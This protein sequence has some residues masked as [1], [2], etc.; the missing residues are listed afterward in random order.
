MYFKIRQKFLLSVINTCAKAISQAAPHPALSG[1]KINCYENYLEFIGS[2]SNISI[3]T[4]IYPDGDNGLEIIQTG[5]VVID[6]KYLLEIIRKIKNDLIEIEVIDGGYTKISSS[7]TE[8]KINGLRVSEYPAIDF[9][10]NGDFFK[11]KTSHL[12]N[13]IEDTAFAISESEI[14]PALTGINLLGKDNTI[15]AI[16]TDSYRL[17][18]KIINTE[19]T[20]DFTLIIPA[21][22]LK[23]IH[24]VI[25]D[26]E[27]FELAVSTKKIQI[28]TENTLL[29]TRL[30]DEVYPDTSK[31]IAQE[32]KYRFLVETR[33]LAEAIDR[34]L[35]IR[36]EG[37][38]IV[39]MHIVDN[40]I[41]LT[42]S[43]Q[44]VG[45]YKEDIEIK[46]FQGEEITI[47]CSGKF[48]LEAL[49]SFKGDEVEILL[50][51]EL[52]PIILRRKNDDSLIQLVS[53]VRTYN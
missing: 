37:K 40:T 53:P 9:S 2:D 46:E 47:S 51:G 42:S 3:K 18:K 38:N 28:K 22:S 5:G 13:I 11:F 48:L 12:I 8:F 17:A 7:K 52:K 15:T 41:H 43:N 49:R 23:D 34:T 20:R 27:E 19:L 35:F 1:I 25:I 32:F 26:D 45:S 10:I 6:S 4:L 21:K 44:E 50:N 16:A 33:K 14:R 36:Q 31:F 30:I 29:Q 39:K 24:N